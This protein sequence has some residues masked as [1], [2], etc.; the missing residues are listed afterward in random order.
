MLFCF[1]RKLQQVHSAVALAHCMRIVQVT[2]D[3]DGV[4]VGYHHQELSGVDFVFVDHP[5]YNR[6]GGMYGDENGVYGDNQWRFKLLCQAALEVPLNLE[7]AEIDNS[8]PSLMDLDVSSPESKGSHGSNG[9]GRSASA[10]H[11]CF[12]STASS[13]A[14]L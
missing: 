3:L 12:D 6:P 14:S 8:R 5:S 2:V 13:F 11:S 1:C 7:L 10:F 4:E 9:A